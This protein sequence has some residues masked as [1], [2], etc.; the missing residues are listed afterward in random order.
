MFHKSLTSCFLNFSC[1]CDLILLNHIMYM[2][3]A[4]ILLHFYCM[5]YLM[6]I[7]VVILIVVENKVAESLKNDF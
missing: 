4:S 3:M 6:Y 5:K 7:T 1:N 2:T